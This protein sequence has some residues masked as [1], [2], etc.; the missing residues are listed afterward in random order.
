ME[1][2]NQTPLSQE[3]KDTFCAHNLPEF[4]TQRSFALKDFMNKMKKPKSLK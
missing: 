1:M 4:S 2:L 3:K